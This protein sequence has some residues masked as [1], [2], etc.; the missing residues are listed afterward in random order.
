MVLGVA[1]LG[2]IM[3]GSLDLFAQNVLPYP[4]AN[5]ANSS[6]VWALGAFA[7][8][9]WAAGTTGKTGTTGTAGTAET[10]DTASGSRS[11]ERG[12]RRRWLPALAGTALLLVAVEVYYLAATL[13]QNDDPSM[14]WSPTALLWLL[15]GVLAGTIFG[16][17]GAWSRGPARWRRAVG[18]A[19]P[20]AVL[21]AEAGILAYRSGVGDATYRR[22]RLSTAAIEAALGVVL[23]LVV[24]RGTRRRLEALAFSAP[25]ALIGFCGFVVAGFGG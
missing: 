1:V 12:S 13:V 4:W 2:G 23:V 3:L 25:L 20:T 11:G 18:V 15:F 5:L 19:L 22:D 14:L 9:A 10:A 6:A 8:G 7:G 16:T 17:A 21:L 24:G